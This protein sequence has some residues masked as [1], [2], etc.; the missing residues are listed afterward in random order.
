MTVAIYCRKLYG[1]NAVHHGLLRKARRLVIRSF[2]RRVSVPQGCSGWSFRRPLAVGQLQTLKPPKMETTAEEDAMAT[3]RCLPAPAA[4]TWRLS[5]LANG[6]FGSRLP[7]SYWSTVEP[8][9][10]QCCT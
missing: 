10:T 7:M 4:A 2:I 8:A 6:V 1:V 3:D 5:S 9:H